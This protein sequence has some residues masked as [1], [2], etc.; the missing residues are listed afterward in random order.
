MDQANFN[1]QMEINSQESII[2][3][4]DMVEVCSPGPTGEFTAV[5][6]LITSSMVKAFFCSPV[7]ITM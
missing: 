5:I 7:E 3:I 2:Y 4:R 1:F 6:I